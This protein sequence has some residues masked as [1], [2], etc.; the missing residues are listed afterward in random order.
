MR[1]KIYNALVNRIP[2]IAYRYHR[3]HKESSGIKKVISWIYLLWLN[4][5]YYVLFCRFLGKVPDA[6]VYE[7][8]KVPCNASE[9]ELASKEFGYDADSLVQKLSEYQVFSFDVFGTLIF[10]P[11]SDPTDLFFILGERFGILDFKNKRVLA[12]RRAR[13]KKYKKEGHYEVTLK[14]IWTELSSVTSISIDEGMSAEIE[15]ELDLCF[16]NPFMLDVWKRLSETGKKLIIVSDMYMPESFISR[17]LEKNGFTGAEKIYVS[18]EHNINKY[19]G[20]IYSKVLDEIGSGEKIIHIGDDP[21]SDVM[22]AEKAG[23]EVLHYPQINRFDRLY[24][25]YDMSAIVGSAYRGIV[26]SHIYNCLNN[27]SMEYEYG[28]IYGGLFVLGYCNFIH[29]QYVK[30]NFDKVLFLSRDGDILKQVYERLFP[31]DRTAYALWSRKAAAKLMAGADTSDYVRRFITH[32][33]GEGITVGAALDSMEVSFLKD[34]LSKWTDPASDVVLNPEDKLTSKNH[35]ALI[36]FVIHNR[37]RIISSYDEQFAAAKKY[38]EDILNGCKNVCAVDIGW[39]GSGAISLAYLT[40]KVWKIP[41]A[42]SGIVAGTNTPH[43]AEPDASESFLQSGKLKSYMFSQ[44]HNRDLLKKHDPG[45]GYNV[46]WELLLS[47][48]Q[49]KFLGFYSDGPHFEDS[50]IDLVKAGEIQK[51]ILDFAKEYSE[52]FSKYPYLLHI[53]GRDAYAPV[54]AASGNGEKYLNSLKNRFSLD[55]GVG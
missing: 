15:T 10:R 51:G 38:Y 18:C 8:K 39:A 19:E 40:E 22:M 16:A 25:P 23:I 52:K 45:K 24:R 5:A 2:G 34:E 12:E 1:L 54:L 20:K 26:D 11:F 53:S 33:I 55:E 4:F 41:C 6:E 17:L 3:F 7:T 50:D 30:E 43:N 13:E 9:S 47:S 46:F 31:E 35:E 29:E 49:A 44:S 42:V 27:Y 28:F 14:E 37:N 32:R 48:P 21:R 36:G